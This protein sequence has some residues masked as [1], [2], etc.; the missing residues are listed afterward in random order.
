MYAQVG[1]QEESVTNAASTSGLGG[2]DD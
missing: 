1:G 2:V